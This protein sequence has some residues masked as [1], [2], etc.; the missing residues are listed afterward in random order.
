MFFAALWRSG[1]FREF[2]LT[3]GL[4]LLVAIQAWRFAGLGFLALYTHK[5]LPGGFALPAGLGDMA[6]GLA[7]PRLVVSLVRR[8]RFAASTAFILWNVLGILDLVVA[9]GSGVLSALSPRSLGSDHDGPHGAVAAPAHPGLPG[10]Y[11][12]HAARSF[13]HAGPTHGQA[14]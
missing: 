7:A 14:N 13:T 4:R 12:L 10:T 2:V 5:V 11:L 1:A 3:A 6:I 9:V 8:P